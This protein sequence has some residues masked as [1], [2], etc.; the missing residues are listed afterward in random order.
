M[1]TVRTNTQNRRLYQLFTILGI[2]DKEARAGMAYLYSNGRTEKTSQL[3]I[4]ECNNL[5]KALEQQT[6]GAKSDVELAVKRKRAKVLY[7]AVEAGMGANG[8]VDYDKFNA[9]MLNTSI[10]KK[11][12]VDC[13]ELELSKLITQLQ[14]IVKHNTEAQASKALAE[15]LENTKV[16]KPRKPR[17][18]KEKA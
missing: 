10:C 18:P 13:N 15:L 3:S 17:K 8:E 6:E 12:L 7:L 14:Q 4:S 16:K 1:Q 2:T 5:I 11:Q 9:F